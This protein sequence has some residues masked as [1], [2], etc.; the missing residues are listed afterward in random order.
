MGQEELELLPERL[1]K[2]AMQAATGR[3]VLSALR[4]FGFTLALAVVE[5]LGLQPQGGQVARQ[6]LAA[7]KLV[8]LEAR[9]VQLLLRHRMELTAAEG[10]LHLAVVAAGSTLLEP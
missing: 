7:C 5:W 4:L 2:V 6:P 8:L 9:Q 3:G 1:G 10:H